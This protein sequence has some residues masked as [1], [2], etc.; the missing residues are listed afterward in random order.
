M[1][2]PPRRRSEGPRGAA[3]RSAAER[4]RQLLAEARRVFAAQGYAATTPEQVA[5]AA[6]VTPAVLARDFA[7]K[8]ALLAGLLDELR[9][10]ALDRW[11]ADANA[12]DPLARLH[13]AADLYLDLLGSRADDVRI[14]HRLLTGEADEEATAVLR[15]F[16]LECEAF[17]SRIIVEGQQ[18]GVFRRSL[19]PRVGAWQLIQTAVGYTLS[20]PLAPPLYAE[21]G[22]APRAVE[23]LLHCL[24][25][26]DV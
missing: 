20:R 8:P 22:Y 17:L 25:K 2:V 19:D 21:A 18:S 24:L 12:A 14:L 13:T 4:R 3:R 6:G 9:Q 1:T 11:P 15:A 26:T 7:D 5:E 23:C 16:A 10:A